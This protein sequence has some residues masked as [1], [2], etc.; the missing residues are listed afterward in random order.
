MTRKQWLVIILL[1]LADCLVLGGLVFVVVQTSRL[2]AA[3]PMADL[4]LTPSPTATPLLPPTW[5]PTPTFTPAPTF[6][7]RP[8]AT[9]APPTP[10]ITPF[11]TFTPTPIPPPELVN[12]TFDQITPFDIPGWT[13]AAVA[14][15]SSGQPYDPENSYAY[16]KFKYADDPVRFITGNTLQIESTDQYAK[17]QLTLYQVVNVPTGTQVQFE[18]KAKGYANEGGIQ[19]RA[20][21][22]PNGGAACEKGQW[23]ATQ[24]INQNNGLVILRSP[25]V[26]V[27]TEGRVTVCVYARPDWAVPHKAAFFDDARLL[28]FP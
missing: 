19:V 7:P 5:T 20:G 18:I 12:G 21:I 1:G 24:S 9:P 15:W 6:T 17:F 8:T 3:R 10:T 27:G 26:R 22:D 28:V 13:V 11:P 23:S 4:S 2:I 16:P 25:R 14:N